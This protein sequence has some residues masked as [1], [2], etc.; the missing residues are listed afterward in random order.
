MCVGRRCPFHALAARSPSAHDRDAMYRFARLTSLVQLRRASVLPV[1][2][3]CTVGCTSPHVICSLVRGWAGYWLHRV[4]IVVTALFIMIRVDP[5]G[6][7]FYTHERTFGSIRAIRRLRFAASVSCAQCRG[8]PGAAD[9]RDITARV[10]VK[11]VL[12]AY[13]HEAS[14]NGGAVD[15]G[16]RLASGSGRISSIQ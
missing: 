1:S 4:A 14:C 16:R 5:L 9:F 6:A 2:L 7:R 10:C 13:R 15:M 8:S 11:R 12:R 3:L